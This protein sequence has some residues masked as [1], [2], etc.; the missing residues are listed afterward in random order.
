MGLLYDWN[1]VGEV[2]NKTFCMLVK[3]LLFS[4]TVVRQQNPDLGRVIVKV[5]R[6][7]TI[8]NTHTRMIDSCER[9]I[10]SSE[11]PLP[12]Q[13]TTNKHP[14]SQGLSNPQSQ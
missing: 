9:V 2:W 7:E 10:S 3:L 14:C 5:S 11:R 8:R 13:H 6:S 4:F 1:S 12:T